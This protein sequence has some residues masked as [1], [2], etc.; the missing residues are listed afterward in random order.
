MPERLYRKLKNQGF[1]FIITIM[2]IS[3]SSIIIITIIMVYIHI[4][5]NHIF[6]PWRELTSLLSMGSDMG[7]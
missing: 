5:L 1:I 3:S 4:C 7:P 2:I 6:F